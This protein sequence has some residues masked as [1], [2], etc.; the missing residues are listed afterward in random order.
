VAELTNEYRALLSERRYAVLATH[1]PEGTIHQT[2]VWFLF[3]EDRF[4]I[5]SYSASSKVENLRRM[6]AASITV[7]VRQ[8]GLDCWVSASGTTDVL[9]GSEAEAINARIVRRYLTQE[10]I[11]DA[12]IGP[13]FASSDDVTIRLIPSKWRS[14]SARDVDERFFGGILGQSPERWFLPIV[15]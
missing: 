14:W 7:D 12:R 2:P 9:S 5:E 10:A 11:E 3:E 15:N 8:P 13:V 1:D 4:Y 6:P